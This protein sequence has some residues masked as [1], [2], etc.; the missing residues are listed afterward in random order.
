[1]VYLECRASRGHTDPR[2]EKVEK[3]KLAVR[4]TTR[5]G[6]MITSKDK[7]VRK[8]RKECRVQEETEGAKD[9]LG[10]VDPEE[11]RA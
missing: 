1:M 3:D 9:L 10:R 7:L 5:P 11:L 4:A 6:Y 8:D 2:E